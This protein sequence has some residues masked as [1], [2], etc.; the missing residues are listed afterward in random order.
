MANRPMANR[1]MAERRGRTATHPQCGRVGPIAVAMG[2]RS[3]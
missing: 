3:F 1:P 2:Y